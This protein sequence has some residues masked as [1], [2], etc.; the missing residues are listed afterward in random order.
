MKIQTKIALIFTMLTSGI[1]VALSIFIYT[2]GSESV[3]NS[4]YHRLE[5]RSDIIGHAALQESKSTTSIYYDIKERHLGDLPFE[6]HHIIKNGEVDK[7]KRLKEQLPMPPSFYD[8]IVRKE[9][10][11][12]FKNDTSYVG[13]NISQGGKMIIVL[14]SAVDLYGLEEIENLK[15]LLTVGFFISM[16]FVFTFGKLFSTQV[17]NP[18]RRI[19]SNV[20]GISAHNLHQRLEVAGSKDEIDDLTHTFNDM[21][22]RL[23]ITFEIQNNFVSNASHEFKTPLTV[24]SGEAQLGLSQEGIPEAAKVAFEA[25]YREAGKLEHLANSMLKLAQ[26]GFDGTKEQWSSIRVDE[27]VLS[28]KEAVDKIIPDNK[29]EINFNHLPEDEAKLTINGNQTLLTAALSNIVLNSCKYSDNKPVNIIISADKNNSIVE[30]VDVGIGIPD[31]EIAQIYVPFFRA[32][33]TERYK[34][35][36]IGLPLANNI[37]KKHNGTIAVNSQV[38]MGTSFKIFLPFTKTKL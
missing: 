9:P 2:F 19:V 1:I 16:I 21:L 28:V 22:N 35:Y 5:V 24:I 31:R 17:F 38:G 12:F 33:N 3:S 25:I 36:G 15:K 20:K 6:Q 18:I 34:G 7:A 8:N 27:L 26:T 10:A 23:E 30:I 4:F 13:L 37:I 29:V 32:S 14:S 11:R